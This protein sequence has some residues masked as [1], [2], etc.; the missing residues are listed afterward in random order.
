L[1]TATIVWGKWC[2]A[3]RVAPLVAIWPTVMIAA[4]AFGWPGA[5]WAGRGM[6]LAPISDGV[7]LVSV[8]LMALLVLI[9][10]AAITSLGLA[11]ATW[12]P[13][14]GRAV[15]LCV[16]AYVMVSVGWMILIFSLISGPRRAEPLLA[17]SP[18]FA[19]VNLC[20]AI[21]LP[22][23]APVWTLA[24]TSFWL[25]AVAASAAVLLLLAYVSFDLCLGRMPDGLSR[26]PAAA[27]AAP[28]AGSRGSRSGSR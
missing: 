17:L 26:P 15:G 10:G 13:R 11:L 8:V 2:G 28:E 12:I 1:S 9:H 4:F 7:R 3:F 20:E 14:Q 23:H 16:T 24:I 22:N 19:S 6:A 25:M 27:S 5:S 18:I 21:A